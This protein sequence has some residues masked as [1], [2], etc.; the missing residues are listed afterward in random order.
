MWGLILNQEFEMAKLDKS[1]G[2]NFCSETNIN[3]TVEL[4]LSE[5]TGTVHYSE[6]SIHGKIIDIGLLEQLYS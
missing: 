3:N 1:K 6:I 4:V 5:Q 2:W